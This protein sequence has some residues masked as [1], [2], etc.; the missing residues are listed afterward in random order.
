MKRTPGRPPLDYHDPS[1][2]VTISLPSKQLDEYCKRAQRDDVSV[3]E[4]IRRELQEK[5]PKK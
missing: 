5:K 4:I 3:P 2:R 1:A